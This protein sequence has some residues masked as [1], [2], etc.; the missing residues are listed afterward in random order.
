MELEHFVNSFQIFFINTH[1]H[2]LYFHL[3]LLLWHAIYP[4]F[5]IM[6]YGPMSYYDPILS[7]FFFI[8]QTNFTYIWASIHH[9][10]DLIKLIKKIMQCGTMQFWLISYFRLIFPW[11]FC[12][13][14]LCIVLFIVLFD[15]LRYMVKK[16]YYFVG[17]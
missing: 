5:L 11:T 8:F 10:Y 14:F 4:F 16:L 15:W 12:S 2:R 7:N 3:D 17:S 6:Q 13:I 9:I 1:R